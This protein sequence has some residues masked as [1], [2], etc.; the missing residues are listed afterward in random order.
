MNFASFL[1]G[2]PDEVV[3]RDELIE[4]VWKGYPG[5]DQSLSNAASKFRQ[6]LEEAGGDRNRLETVPKRGYSLIGP[7]QPV[8][9]VRRR[10]VILAAGVGL[11]MLAGILVLTQPIPWGQRAKEASVAVLPFENMSPD[12]DQEYFA[13]GMA[14]E[15]LNVLSQVKGL[16]VAARTSSFLFDRPDADVAEVGRVLNVE[17]VVEGSVRRDGDRVRVTVQLIDADEGFHRWSRTFD[18]ELEDVFEIQDQIAR[19][20]VEA[21]KIE[22]LESHGQRLARRNT[23]SIEAYD[24]YLAG[25]EHFR[26]RGQGNI[27]RHR[28]ALGLFERAVEID[29]EFALAWSGIADYYSVSNDWWLETYMDRD[30]AAARALEAARRAVDIAPELAEAQASLGMALGRFNNDYEQGRVHLRKAVELNPGYAPALHWLGADY[31]H[32]GWL[33]EALPLQER[34]ATLDPLNNIVITWYARTLGAMGRYEDAVAELERVLEYTREADQIHDFLFHEA[35]ESGRFAEAHER[36]E[37]WLMLYKRPGAVG[38]EECCGQSALYQLTK[39]EVAL[40]RFDA[41]R[42]SLGALRETAPE[43]EI[44]YGGGR[45][46]LLNGE[47]RYPELLEISRKPLAS[48][49]PVRIRNI[50]LNFHGRANLLNGNFEAAIESLE[51]PRDWGEWRGRSETQALLAYAYSRAGRPETAHDLAA[52]TLASLEGTENQGTRRPT[53]YFRKAL[54]L[55]LLDRREE[56]LEALE[57]AY[58]WG[59]RHYNAVTVRPFLDRLM[60]DDER[61]AAFIRRVRKD[62]EAMRAKVE[63]RR[64]M[65]R[66]DTTQDNP[67]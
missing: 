51:Q 27:D 65:T 4:A 1:A 12:P 56:A 66:T 32:E 54:L 31:F 21:L 60:G 45:Y 50:A 9:S 67:D 47:G 8:A 46:W 29:P 10:T 40:A 14:E 49:L 28:R 52:Q 13:D 41:A 20:V 16:K 44:L 33:T 6:A 23:D 17:N 19:A 26:K 22:L 57:E 59:W 58:R 36:L 7:V 53:L 62:I 42:T 5:A 11:A 25:R 35:F 64:L 63:S 24:L 61:Y 39:L 2:R 43:A 38:K 37:N 15:L 55:E 18:R 34:A 3:S 48:N 30:A